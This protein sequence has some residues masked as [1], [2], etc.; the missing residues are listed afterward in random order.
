MNETVENLRNIALVAHGGAG[1]TSLSEAML[2]N[3]GAIKRLERVE[4]GNTAMDF[5]PEEIKRKATINS[6]FNHYNWGGNSIYLI[7]TPGDDNFLNDAVFAARI[8]DNAIFVLEANT[9]LS[10]P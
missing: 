10:C 2:F 8:A 6:S 1:K 3:T 7:D 9:S 5:E 4:N